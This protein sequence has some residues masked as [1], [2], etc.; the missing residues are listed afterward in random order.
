MSK[1]EGLNYK[2][3]EILFLSFAEFLSCCCR[4][5][6]NRDYWVC[7]DY[8]MACLR[9]PVFS[10]VLLSTLKHICCS[11]QSYALWTSVEFCALI[12]AM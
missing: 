3:K 6:N 11:S 5:F 7:C 10:K 4:R 2:C 8:V 1:T 12:T 9:V